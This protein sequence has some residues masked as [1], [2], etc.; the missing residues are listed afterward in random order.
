MHLKSLSHGLWA[1]TAPQAPELSS[2]EGEQNAEVA[3]IGGGYTGLSA[4]LHLA[5]AGTDVVSP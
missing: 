4:A 1:D 5:E 3:I 2:L